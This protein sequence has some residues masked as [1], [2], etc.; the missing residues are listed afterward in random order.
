MRRICSRGCR[1]EPQLAFAQVRGHGSWQ[2]SIRAVQPKVGRK[3]RH[4]RQYPC[5]VRIFVEPIAAGART[6]G[7]RIGC[8]SGRLQT[9][10]RDRDSTYRAIHR[11]LLLPPAPPP[12]QIRRASTA[13]GER[14]MATPDQR[15]RPGGMEAT[16]EVC[17]TTGRGANIEVD[18]WLNRCVGRCCRAASCCACSCIACIGNW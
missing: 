10:V 4:E 8:V 14:A 16:T 15:L 9:R 17:R 13:G 5:V 11:Q 3:C 7:G 12:A 6:R 2:V 18:Q 1:A